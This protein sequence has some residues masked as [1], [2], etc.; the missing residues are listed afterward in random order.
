MARCGPARRRKLEEILREIGEPRTR[1]WYDDPEAV[2]QFILGTREFVVQFQLVAV[3]IFSDCA[4][5]RLDAIDVEEG[6][7]GSA[8]K[9]HAELDAFVP[10]VEDA[11]VSANNRLVQSPGPD[12]PTEIRF[13]YE[14]A[15]A[16]VERSPRGAAA[17]LRLCIQ[18]L[19]IHLGVKGKNL[20]DDIGALVR[21]GLPVR[22]QQ[23][24]D[25]VRLIGNNAVHPGELDLEDYSETATALFDLLNLNS[26]SR[27]TQLRKIEE[28]YKTLPKTSR[29]AIDKRHR[30][31]PR[32]S[33][34][35]EMPGRPPAMPRA[36][37]AS[38]GRRLESGQRRLS[39]HAGPRSES[40]ATQE[41]NA[42]PQTVKRP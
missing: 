28:L 14:E 26:G 4:V 40:L 34:K 7:F 3:P 19:C 11:L 22:I 37:T 18:E 10:I 25:M 15:K 30:K 31:P 29:D 33:W 42:P 2:A 1:P 8:C 24:L 6:S 20:N 27:P 36:C 21:K 17:L 5:R 41:C 12:L 13:D 9:A 23:A 16:I 35:P 32:E 39:Y 38:V